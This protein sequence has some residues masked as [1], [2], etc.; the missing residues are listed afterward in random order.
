MKLF[1]LCKKKD[2]PGFRGGFNLLEAYPIRFCNVIE[3][4]SS[5]V[6]PS[7]FVFTAPQQKVEQVIVNLCPT[8]PWALPNWVT[9]AHDTSSFLDKLAALRA[10]CFPAAK[11]A[12]AISEKE[13]KHVTEA[14]KYAG[15]TDWMTALPLNPKYPQNDPVVL[16]RVVLHA[17]VEFGVDTTTQGILILD[18]PTIAAAYESN[19]L[20]NKVNSRFIAISGTGLK[21]N[22]VIRVELGATIGKLLGGRFKA[23]GAHRV[24]VNGPLC[25]REITDLALEID[26]SVN[27]IVVLEA[28]NV[29]VMFPMI[30]Q[31]EMSFTTNILGEVRRCVYCNFCDDICP[32]DLEPA[33]YYHSY[34]RGEGHKARSYNLG[35]C[36]ECGL[37]SFICPSKLELLQTIKACKALD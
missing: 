27:N 1:N 2:I 15:N 12:I 3:K 32:M 16:S 8:E 10:R 25:G 24:F 34:T 33:L 21:E 20:G 17:E 4:I 30:K 22:E 26:W 36:I 35:K 7:Q 18:A 5:D 13:G 14:I 9:L 6:A 11:V 37:C 29:K 23:N 31:E 19:V 28:L